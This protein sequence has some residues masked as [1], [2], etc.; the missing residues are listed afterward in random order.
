MEGEAAAV[1][2]RPCGAPGRSH[3]HRDTPAVRSGGSR[4]GSSRT[5][6]LGNTDHSVFTRTRVSGSDWGGVSGWAQQLWASVVPSV[7]GVA[8]GPSPGGLRVGGAGRARCWRGNDGGSGAAARCPHPPARQAQGC[9]GPFRLRR[10]LLR[11]RTAL[12]A[13]SAGGVPLVR[14]GV[15][16]TRAKPQRAPAHRGLPPPPPPST[17]GGAGEPGSNPTL[18]TVQPCG[19]THPLCALVSLPVKRGEHS[20][21]F[22]SWPLSPLPVAPTFSGD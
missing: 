22:I 19:W 5:A 4:S 18:S 1:L 11:V 13:G 7:N 10:R 20:P 12:P 16:G 8:Q 3:T 17:V 2:G 15:C 21:R 6:A 9:K 14:K